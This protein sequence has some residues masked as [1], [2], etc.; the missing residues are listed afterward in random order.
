MVAIDFKQIYTAWNQCQRHK[1]KSPQAQHYAVNLLDN[2]FYTLDALQQQRWQPVAPIGFV[3]HYPKPREVYAASFSDRV[4]HHWLV[5]QLEQCYQNY[6][7]TDVYSNLKGKG[8]HSAVKRLQKFMRSLADKQPQAYFLQLDVANFFN[9]IDKPVLFQLLQRRLQQQLRKGA[10]SLEK[11][12]D[13]R[14]ICHLLLKQNVGGSAKHYGNTDEWA[15]IPEHKKLKNAGP[16][17]G[18]PIGNL[19]SQF[20]ANVYL[21]ELDQFV[22]HQLKCQ[23]YLRYVDDFILLHHDPQQLKIWH[24]AIT[25]F[26]QQQLL[27]TLRSEIILHPVQHGANFLGYIVRPHYCL[28]RRRVIGQ[29]WQKLKQFQS[30]YISGSQEK[31][32]CVSLPVAAREHLRAQLSSYLGHFKHAKHYRLL[33]R[34]WQRF[35]WLALLFRPYQCQLII[36]WKPIYVSGFSSQQ[37][38]FQASYPNATVC[39]QKGYQQILL[40]P[41]RVQQTPLHKKNA[42]ATQTDTFVLL[43]SDTRAQVNRVMVKQQGY[44]AGGLRERCVS[45]LFINPGVTLC[46]H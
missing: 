10:I 32:W 29:L 31:G 34:V 7:I 15:Q 18:L 1:G 20:F 3:V 36:L 42:H 40:P 12:Q 2:L 43:S 4:V 14:L 24:D 26:I 6:F 37:A 39:I 11:A 30:C 9:T 23:H 13:L 8:T 22:K 41:K 19:S 45:Q 21:N 16:D 35:L 38:Y 28:V 33:T 27:L 46:L 5:P 25:Q 17:K 44:L